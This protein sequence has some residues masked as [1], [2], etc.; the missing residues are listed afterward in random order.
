MKNFIIDSIYEM[1]LCIGAAST[2][3]KVFKGKVTGD[4]YNK[5]LMAHAT[6]WDWKKEIQV[7]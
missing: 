5:W 6:K 7:T 1:A 4:T 3:E 2:S